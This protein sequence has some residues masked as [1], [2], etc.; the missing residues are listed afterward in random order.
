VTLVVGPE[1]LLRDRAVSAVVAAAR[2]VDAQTEV[3]DLPASG[4]EPGQVTSLASPSL[5]GER[6]VIVVRDVQDAG[7]E[8]TDEL[9]AYLTDV[10]PVADDTSLVLVHAGGVKG[11]SLLDAVRK[12]GAAVVDCKAVKYEREKVA[13]VLAEFR[14]ARRRVS[15]DA[16]AA[17]VD[18]VGSDLREL[19]NACSQLL[20]DTTGTVDPEVVE[21]YYGGRVEATGFKVA[22]AALEGR[23]E[24][25]LRLL[26]QALATGGDP[27][28][29]NAA[30]A[31]GLRNLARVASAPSH[32]RP[33]DLAR[34]LG[35]APFQVRRAREQ[36]AG[37]SASG[38]AGAITA[39]AQADAEI[40][41]AATDPVYALERAVVTVARSRTA[42]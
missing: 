42:R 13:F 1:D 27:V 11:K 28:P 3:R 38:V 39:V 23:C 31:M 30:L 12:S 20:A 36:R 7:E 19:A 29:I 4:L 35:L 37:W 26:R 41:G 33:D 2:A 5:F 40:K 16:A 14:D 10:A 25:A 18:A 8:I 34:E 24:D 15:P 22:D 6:K 32:V 17:L 9:K 21:R